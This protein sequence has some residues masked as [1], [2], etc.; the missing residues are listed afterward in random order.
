MYVSPTFSHAHLLLTPL[1]PSQDKA[2]EILI[3]AGPEYIIV[4]L[5]YC[6][7]RPT[8]FRYRPDNPS[9][10][11]TRGELAKGI[12][13]MYQTVYRVEEE[14]MPEKQTHEDS[15]GRAFV[16]ANRSRTT[17]KVSSVVIEVLA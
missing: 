8:S 14:T 3:P 17:G 6:L 4:Q 15:G 9:L 10:G 1:S 13:T 16:F 11:Y 5:T 2:N 12:S 7:G